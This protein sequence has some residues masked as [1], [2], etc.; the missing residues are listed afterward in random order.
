MTFDPTV[1]MD[2][3]KDR[4]KFLKSIMSAAE[5]SQAMHT[6]MND[7]V[8]QLEKLLDKD[9]S[10]NPEESFKIIL[11]TELALVK[12]FRIQTE[13]NLTLLTTALVYAQG[14]S[15]QSDITKMLIKMGGNGGEALRQMWKNKMG[16]K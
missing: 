6:G 2:L 1:I 12:S 3:L 10:V 16:G 15:F 8:E 4:Q 11:R 5:K 14:S 13:T 7:M 9:M